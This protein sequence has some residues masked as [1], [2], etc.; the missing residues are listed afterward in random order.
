MSE[1]VGFAVE[2][3]DDAAVVTSPGADIVGNLRADDLTGH[4]ASTGGQLW[5]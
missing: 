1:A 2:L 3:M 5:Q 4:S